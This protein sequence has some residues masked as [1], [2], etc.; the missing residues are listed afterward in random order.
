MSEVI[1]YYAQNSSYVFEQFIRHFLISLYGVLFA[2]IIAIPLGF[3]VARKRKLSR[4][5]I[6]IANVM[7]TI[8]SLAMLAMLMFLIGTG[9]NTVVFAVFLYA[10]L[11]I[12]KNTV[13][14]I[15][16]VTPE[17][18]DAAM[19]MGMTRIQL[20]TKVELPLAISIIMGGIR[21]AL[22]LAI[23]VTAVGTFIGAGGLGDIITRGITVANGSPIII[24][25][26]IPTA[27]M[28]VLADFILGIIENKL[29]PRTF[30]KV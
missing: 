5:T 2:S 11:P 10:I 30:T 13:S 21:N 8:P 16:S 17:L 23:G 7:Q 19:G 27:L 18:V 14:G 24:A 6:S 28:A 3:F 1:M 12:L 4:L 20:M 22:V 26:A 29:T 15:N 25:G 9:P